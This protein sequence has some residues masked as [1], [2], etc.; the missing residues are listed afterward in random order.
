MVS[1][2]FVTRLRPFALRFCSGDGFCHTS[3]GI[4][5]VLVSGHR[6]CTTSNGIVLLCPCAI[7]GMVVKLTMSYAKHTF[8]VFTKSKIDKNQ[9]CL[10]CFP[11]FCVPVLFENASKYKGFCLR[12]SLLGCHLSNMLL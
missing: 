10:E 8:D 1:F 7:F 3:N 6:F 2:P 9:Q 12:E 5:L 11:C 4:L